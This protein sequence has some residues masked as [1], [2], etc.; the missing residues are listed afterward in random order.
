MENQIMGYILDDG[1]KPAAAAQRWLA[2][3]PAV[4]DTWLDGITTLDGKPAT[5]VVKSALES[6]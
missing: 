4:L 3:N 2:A 6:L 5:P 1:M